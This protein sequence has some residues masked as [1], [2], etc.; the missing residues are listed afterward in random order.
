MTTQDKKVDTNV[1]ARTGPGPT[2][3]VAIE[4]FFP[5]EQRIIHDELALKILPASYRFFIKLMRPA[6]IRDWIV[7]SAEKRIPGIWSG[8]LCRKRYIDEKVETA[9]STHAVQAIVNLGAGYDT[10]LYRLPGLSNIPIWEVDQPG[11]IAS[12][13]KGVEN[14]LGKVPTNVT[15]TAINFMKQ[16]IGNVLQANGYQD[17]SPTFFIWEAVSQ[18]LTETAVRQTFQFLAQ[19]PSGSQL[20]FTYVPKDFIAGTNMYG[21]EKFYERIII[22]AKAWHFGFMPPEVAPFLAEYGWRLVEDL[23]YAELGKRYAKR[24]LSAMAIERM[25]YAE[26]I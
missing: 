8:M 26:K 6:P 16:E 4:Q 14:A 21:A 5:P 25:V 22:Q 11:N 18:Y 2:S 23:S 10:R 9:V 19:A 24:N 7:R 1:A 12:K 3:I 15:L 13:Q 17:N 20:A